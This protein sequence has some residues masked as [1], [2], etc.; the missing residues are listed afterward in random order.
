MFTD[1]SNYTNRKEPLVQGKPALQTFGQ[2]IRELRKQKN[3]GQRAL[4]AQVG[5]SFTYV[6]RIENE[7]LDFGPYPSDELI[8]K[9]AKALDADEDELLLLAQKV[10]DWIRKRVLERP[11]AFRMI[12]ELDDRALDQ[13]LATIRA[14]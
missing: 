9:L 8:R 3:L 7:N 12:A 13:V 14:R 4:A 11:D 2:R 5:V 10:P 6:S 1:N